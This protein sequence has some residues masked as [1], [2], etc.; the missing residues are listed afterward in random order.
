TPRGKRLNLPPV[1][2]HSW[3]SSLDRP[4]LA[5][6]CRH[7]DWSG[8]SPRI[9]QTAQISPGS[10][11][12]MRASATVRHSPNSRTIVLSTTSSDRSCVMAVAIT[13]KG[14]GSITETTFIN[15]IESP[16]SHK[17][18]IAVTIFRDSRFS[19]IPDISKDGRNCLHF[20]QLITVN[21]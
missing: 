19:V 5:A 17:Y 12:Q 2:D 6:R 7:F 16:P 10:I 14:S 13:C 11:S 8:H 4:P 21:R 3:L 15:P 1:F 18:Q 20:H 9:G